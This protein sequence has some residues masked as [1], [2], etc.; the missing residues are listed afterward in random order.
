MPNLKY[1]KREI[2]VIKKRQSKEPLAHKKKFSC[3]SYDSRKLFMSANLLLVVL[4]VILWSNIVF[5]FEHTVTIKQILLSLLFIPSN[6]TRY[7]INNK[8][9]WCE[10]I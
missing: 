5:S 9:C 4:Y 8:A 2:E 3:M 7:S 1:N 10:L 6:E